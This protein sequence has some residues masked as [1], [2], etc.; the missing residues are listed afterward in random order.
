MCQQKVHIIDY[1]KQNINIHVIKLCF[2]PYKYAHTNSR[3]S[4]PNESGRHTTTPVVNVCPGARCFT[5]TA[6]R[7]SFAV[8]RTLTLLKLSSI[9]NRSDI[10]RCVCVCVCVC[11]CAC[12]I[13]ETFVHLKCVFIFFS[14]S[15]HQCMYQYIVQSSVTTKT[16][17]NLSHIDISTTIQTIAKTIM[18][19]N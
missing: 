17:H 19:T 12:G 7:A 4:Y 13:K 15:T 5:T 1:F 18:S 10:S 9:S 16:T 11:V 2:S 6:H 3:L 14:N 8:I